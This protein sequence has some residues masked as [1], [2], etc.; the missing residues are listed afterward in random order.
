MQGVWVQSLIQELKAHMLCSKVTKLK[1]TKTDKQ[2]TPSPKRK[3]TEV[4]REGTA[5]WKTR[6]KML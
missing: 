2:P 6:S 4:R 5:T 3:K 1:Q